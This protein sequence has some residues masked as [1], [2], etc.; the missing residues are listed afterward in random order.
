[1]PHSSDYD[2][3]FTDAKGR[4]VT[5]QVAN[6]VEAFHEGMKVGS[7]CFDEDDAGFVSLSYMEVK[8]SFRR[9]GIAREM[10]RLAAEVHGRKFGRPDFAAYGGSGADS[11]SYFTPDGAGLIEDCI[12]RGVIDDLPNPEA[13]FFEEDL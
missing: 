5:F 12:A 1:M 11:R 3:E 10:I 7:V 8:P 9:A 6:D 13:R 2:A 4:L